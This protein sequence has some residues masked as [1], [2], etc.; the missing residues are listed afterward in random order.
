MNREHWWFPF[1]SCE[2]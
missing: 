1:I 2:W